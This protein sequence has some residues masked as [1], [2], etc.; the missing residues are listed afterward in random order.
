[1]C[2]TSCQP[3]E[4]AV[5]SLVGFGHLSS[6]FYKSLRRM[7]AREIGGASSFV[8]IV[9]NIDQR[10]RLCLIITGLVEVLGSFRCHRSTPSL[11]TSPISE[12]RSR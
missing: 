12:V 6:V 1:M 4:L 2:V 5:H 11:R 7:E 9:E 10:P 8:G 3:V